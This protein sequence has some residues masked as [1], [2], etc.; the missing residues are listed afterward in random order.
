MVAEWCK[1]LK[2]HSKRC[3]IGL[4]QLDEGNV[5]VFSNEETGMKATPLVTSIK[6]HIS[7]CLKCTQRMG[8]STY[9]DE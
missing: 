6:V 3:H 2:P 1:V 7:T 9:G 5:G 8:S 4:T